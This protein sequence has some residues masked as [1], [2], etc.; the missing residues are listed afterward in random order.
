MFNEGYVTFDGVSC[1]YIIGK[2]SIKLIPT[3]KDD[4]RRLNDHFDDH[5]FIFRY[6]DGVD[7]NCIA[8]IDRSEINIGSSLSLIP[9]YSVKLFNDNPISS[10]EITGPAIDEIFHPS[11]YY[12]FKVKAGG[13][14]N[15]DLAYKTETADKWNI[16][17]DDE[18]IEITLQYGGILGHGIVSDMML[19]PKI[20]ATFQPT[21]D[22][23]F[24]YKMYSIITR[25][26][27]ITQY[28]SNFGECKVYLR[29]EEAEHNS[30][31]LHDWKQFGN[32]R[33]YCNEVEYKYIKPY[34]EKLL[35][36]SA[37]NLGM[38]LHFLPNATYRWKRTDY[39]PNTLSS[40]FAA[41]ESEYDANIA[42]YEPNKPGDISKLKARII[43]RVHEFSSEELSVFEKDF[44]NQVEQR[45]EDTGN[46]A[47]QRRK[48]K[49]VFRELSP[50]LDKCAEHL[51]ARQKIGNKDG[52]SAKE[53]SQIAENIVGLRA[54]VTHVDTLSDFDDYQAEYI[55]FL[56][57]LVH[58]Q[59]L[60]RAGIDDAGIRILLGALF[61]CN[62]EFLSVLLSDNE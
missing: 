23:E 18:S 21:T 34:I 26:L 6:S 40:L 1:I 16:T 33:R 61:H 8:Y 10:M 43:E 19:H 55:H 49:N 36:F 24:I 14:N 5:D 20:I 47:G 53:I 9:I 44:L 58:A 51:F 29:G 54:Q 4:I 56:E 59:M 37:D 38:A 50:V 11:S 35:Q 45:I 42:L 31:Y 39:S 57:I 3:N 17:V 27:Q 15:I 2:E 30:G 25:F 22:Y 28:N 48:V 41:F 7:K 46:R 32:T 60:K 12:Y 13:E 52:F 62:F